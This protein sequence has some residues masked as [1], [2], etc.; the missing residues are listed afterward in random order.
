[1]LFF[2]ILTCICTIRRTNNII[3]AY[4]KEFLD[5]VLHFLFQYTFAFIL[6]LNLI[7]YCW[8]LNSFSSKATST[9]W[10]LTLQIPFRTCESVTPILPS[11]EMPMISSEM[12]GYICPTFNDSYFLTY[13][14]I[15]KLKNFFWYWLGSSFLVEK[16][17][18]LNKKYLISEPILHRSITGDQCF[19]EHSERNISTPLPPLVPCH[20]DNSQPDKCR[21]IPHCSFDCLDD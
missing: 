13:S 15:C 20:F 9:F 10:Y 1:M 4:T 21:I 7:T 19:V 11:F 12:F 2:I 5:L 18:N 6:L 17:E 16:L 8:K 3:Q 14:S